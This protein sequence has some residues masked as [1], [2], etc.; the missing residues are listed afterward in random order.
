[1][2]PPFILGRGHRRLAPH[3]YTDQ[4]IGDLLTMSDRLTP[5]GKC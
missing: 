2:P 3:I 4:E 1:V 5:L